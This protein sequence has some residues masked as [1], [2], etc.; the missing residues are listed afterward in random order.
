MPSALQA[1][2]IVAGTDSV[3]TAL[4][5]ESS[6]RRW[7][8]AGQFYQIVVHAATAFQV[9]A[10]SSISWSQL[11]A[12]GQPCVCLYRRM[13]NGVKPVLFCRLPCSCGQMVGSP[14]AQDEAS[15]LSERRAD[16]NHAGNL[17]HEQVVGEGFHPSS[18]YPRVMQI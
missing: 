8:F 2:C 17:R 12:P 7:L 15:P 3:H 5:A 1:W 10:E 13:W 4:S 6:L 18:V 14:P 9:V 16:Y 11:P